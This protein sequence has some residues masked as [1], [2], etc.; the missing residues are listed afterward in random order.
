MTPR[1]S[2]SFTVFPA[3]DTRV[4]G[5]VRAAGHSMNGVVFG[6]IT[7]IASNLVH[8]VS[9]RVARARACGSESVTRACLPACVFVQ[10]TYFALMGSLGAVSTGLLQCMRAVVVFMISSVLFCSRQES[11]CFTGYRCGGQACARG[12]R[13]CIICAVCTC[14]GRRAASTAVVLAG[15]MV[16][17]WGKAAVAYHK[18]DEPS[19]GGTLMVTL[20]GAAE[21]MRARLLGR[22]SYLPVASR[23]QQQ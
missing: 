22:P 14:G 20:M 18:H 15:V 11:Q 3:W 1:V 23:Q 21:R 10:A 4:E 13:L 7:L 17:C 6:W 12:S 16:Y 9:S 5:S 8:A 2:Q 19:A